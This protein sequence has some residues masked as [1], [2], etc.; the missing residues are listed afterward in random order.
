MESREYRA[1][2][3][4]ENREEVESVRR[5]SAPVEIRTEHLPN[6][7]LK[8]YRYTSSLGNGFVIPLP[9]FA[10]HGVA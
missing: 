5:A 10:G 3:T 1:V 7:S 2:A 8:P 4:E 9:Q 6:K